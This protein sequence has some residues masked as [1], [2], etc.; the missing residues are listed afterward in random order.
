MPMGGR[1]RKREGPWGSSTM[2]HPHHSAPGRT[3]QQLR[4]PLPA[5]GGP[6]WSA[7]G[8]T[9]VTGIYAEVFLTLNPS[10]QRA[11]AA[12]SARRRRSSTAATT[13][14]LRRDEG[15][16]APLKPPVRDVGQDE[17]HRRS[18]DVK[19]TLVQRTV[20]LHSIIDRLWLGASSPRCQERMVPIRLSEVMVPRRRLAHGGRTSP[21]APPIST[22]PPRA[23]HSP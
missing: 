10:S 1:R 15:R 12:R 3:R 21:A 14:P 11:R 5:T 19:V 2:R 22:G 17:R 9:G 13:P 16:D 7:K 8:P 18:L 23:A 6:Q 4:P 20:H